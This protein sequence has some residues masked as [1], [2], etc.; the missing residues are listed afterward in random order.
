MVL[1]PLDALSRTAEALRPVCAVDSQFS[2]VLQDLF[3]N[4]FCRHFALLLLI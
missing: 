1:I 3:F 4:L 2:G